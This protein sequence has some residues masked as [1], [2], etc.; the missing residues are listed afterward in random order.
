MLLDPPAACP[1]IDL[2]QA[3]HGRGGLAGILDEEARGTVSDDLPAG[4]QVHG[5]HGHTGGIGLRQD[6]SESLRDG[7]QMQQGSRLRE[8]SILARDIHGS[9]VPDRAVQVRLYLLGKISSILDNPGNEQ[10]QS[11]QAG[12]I[13]CQVD[14]LV[15]MDPA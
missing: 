1:A 2:I 13:D 14:A 15:R 7:V 9:N 6:E 12:D 11:A 3:E 10:R 8:Q 5:D 4:A